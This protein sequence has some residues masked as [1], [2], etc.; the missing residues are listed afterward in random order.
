MNNEKREDLMKPKKSVF[1]QLVTTK[2]SLEEF[3]IS[4]PFK[5]PQPDLEKQKQLANYLD[6]LQQK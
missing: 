5:D 4:L 6:K 2:S 3:L 1:L